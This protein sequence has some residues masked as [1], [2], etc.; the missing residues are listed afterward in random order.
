M[1]QGIQH[2]V[3]VVNS[4][5]RYSSLSHHR[6]LERVQ[7]GVGIIPGHCMMFIYVAGLPM[8][9]KHLAP[10]AVV[11]NGSQKKVSAFVL[12]PSGSQMLWYLVVVRCY[13]T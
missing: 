11:P 9:R 12:V 5:M 1:V 3:G 13:G 10:D 2:G 4:S 7:H 8:Q 6:M